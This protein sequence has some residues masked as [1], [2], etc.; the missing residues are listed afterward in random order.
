MR[1]IRI[2]QFG[3]GPIGRESLRLAAERPDLEVIGAVEIDPALAGRPAGE[4][5]GCPLPAAARIHPSFAELAAHAGLPDVLLHTAGSDAA[6]SFAQVRPALEAGVSV[7]STCE[8]LIFP[9]LRTPELTDEIDAL[10][11]RTEARLVGTGV[12]PGFVMDVLPLCL[13]GVCREV[14]AV[15][16]ERVVDARTRRQPLQAKIGSGRTRP[17]SANASPLGR[18]GTPG[19]GNRSPC[20]PT[21]WVGGSTRSARPASPSWPRAGSSRPTS[22]WP[23]AAPS[24]CTSAASASLAGKPGSGSTCRCT[25]ALPSPTMRSSSRA[26]LA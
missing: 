1:R 3:L 19:S 2:A 24:V 25:S 17:S 20:S 23:R 14:S 13:T 21:G 15:Y 4:A 11:R 22:R 8:E 26:A 9:R 5:L 18:P 12:N 10:C 16:V 6:R 7:A